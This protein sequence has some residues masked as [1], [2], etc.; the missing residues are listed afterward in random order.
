MDVVRNRASILDAAQRHFLEHG[1]G[2]SLEAVAK[3]AGVGPAT[4]YRHF[5]TR[6][7]VL[8]GVLQ[9]RSKELIEREAQIA[10]VVDAGDALQQWLEALADYFGAYKGLPEPLMR[11]A[12]QRS[13]DNPLTL[14]CEH[15]IHTTEQLV[16]AAKAAGKVEDWVKGYDL[17]LAANSIAWLKSLGADKASLQTLRRIMEEGYCLR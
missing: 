11:A 10:S 6:E 8:A 13:P 2:T 12:R 5:P 15:L 1:V 3:E 7:A 14:S 17:F 9:L 16:A 4:L